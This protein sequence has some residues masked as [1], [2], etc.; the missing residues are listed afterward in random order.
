[1]LRIPL[2]SPISVVGENFATKRGH[3]VLSDRIPADFFNSQDFVGTA[4]LQRRDLFRI[5]PQQVFKRIALGLSAID[6]ASAIHFRFDTAS[7]CSASAFVSKV[8]HRDG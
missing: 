8:L 5:A 2:E 6:E 7:P 1:M 4:L 3:L